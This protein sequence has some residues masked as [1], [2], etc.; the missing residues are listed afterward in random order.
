[1]ENGEVPK[2]GSPRARGPTNS[3]LV[4]NSHDEPSPPR[5]AMPRP[6]VYLYNGFH[7]STTFHEFIE[8]PRADSLTRL[9]DRQNMYSSKR[10]TTS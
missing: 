2:V 1:M 4:Q 3:L 7:S 9:M 8:H 5:Q 10:L 6:R